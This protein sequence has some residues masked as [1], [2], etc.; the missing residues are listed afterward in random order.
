MAA[1]QAVQATLDAR[2]ANLGPDARHP[3]P[4]T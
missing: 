3:M 1:L 4:Q 2:L